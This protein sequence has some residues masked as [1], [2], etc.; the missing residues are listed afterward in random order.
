MKVGGKLFFSISGIET[1]LAQGYIGK[2]I[3]IEKRFFKINPDLQVRFQIFTP[4][5]LYSKEEAEKLFSKYF[6]ILKIEK[7][8]FGNINIVAIKNK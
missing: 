4:I 1:D 8:A 2:K 6:H 3:V 7:T 5:C